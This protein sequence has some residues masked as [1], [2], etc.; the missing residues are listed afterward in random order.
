MKNG[1]LDLS[2]AKIA[3]RNERAKKLY[4]YLSDVARR[5]NDMSTTSKFVAD[6]F[7]TN[8]EVQRQKL[9]DN[10]EKLLFLDPINYGKKALELLWRKVYYD[11]ISTAKKLRTDS[12]H[13]HFLFTLI[14]CGIGNFHHFLDRI[15]YEM[16]VDFKEL[17]YMPNTE[18][19]ELQ[20][21]SGNVELSNFGKSALHSCLIYLGDLSRYAVEISNHFEPTIAARYYL[22]AAHT[23]FTLGM[24]YNQLGNLYLEKNY[25]LD[26]VCFYIHCLNSKNPFEGAMGN[27]TKIF[28]K[29][30]QFYHTINES[31]TLTQVEHIQNTIVNFLSLIE[32]WYLNKSDSDIPQRCS[33]IAQQ[34][35]ICMEFNEATLP[36]I[37]KNY[38]D[39]LSILEHETNF[40]SYLNPNLIHRMVLICLFTVSKMT[41]IDETKAFACKAFTLALL[42]QLLLKLLKQLDSIGFVNPRQI[43]NYGSSKPHNEQ[44]EKYENNN[45][46]NKEI[47]EST[48]NN[49]QNA[50]QELEEQKQNNV[51]ENNLNGHAKHAK[52]ALMKRRRRRRIASSESSDVSDANTES[53]DLDE[54]E[55]SYSDLSDSSDQS[56]SLSEASDCD[57]VNDETKDE[58]SE[59][60]NEKVEPNKILN[61]DITSKITE[62]NSLN[63]SNLLNCNTTKS[64]ENSK[65]NT[66]ELKT[67]LQGNNFMASIKLLLDWILIEKDL[68]LSC[69]DSGESLFQCVVDL[70]NIFTF[71]FNTKSDEGTKEDCELIKYIRNLVMKMKLEYKTIPLPE[72]INLRGTNIC[73]FDK[74]AAEWHILEKYKL[75]VYEE[76]VI[77]ILNFI[78]FGNQ[79][80]KIIPRI[81][82]NRTMKLFYLKNIH[83]PKLNTKINHKRSREWHSKKNTESNESGLL[84]R[85]GRLWLTSQ[86]RELERS[87]QSAAP[88]LLVLDTAALNKH[89]RRVKQ[90]L[91]TTNFVLMVPTVVLQELDNLKREQSTARKAIRWLELQLKNGSR[92]LRAQ[93]PNQSKPLPLLKYP[94]KAPAH[95]NNF[96]QILEFCNHFVAEDKKTQGSG[97][98][99]N[100]LQGKSS[101]VLILLVGNADEDEEQYKEFSVMGAAQSAGIS[102]ENIVDFYSK[103]RQTSHKNGKK[104]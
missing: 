39:Y 18:E 17:D 72:D 31:D 51:K 26:S 56:V 95:I 63:S 41:E 97:D 61:D 103:W 5:I 60:I 64:Q 22:Q 32:I 99:E 88:A 52:K 2:E 101:S 33:K 66:I 23:D 76:N 6:L 10:C 89:L 16:K 85:L 30:D 53:S 87:G 3:E 73:K 28:E 15:H 98:A 19:D 91:L 44:T 94:R 1:C 21:S 13:D 46:E 81:R 77:R 84:R 24:P 104:R 65:V 38:D 47:I 45:D 8:I 82:F 92:F 70:L 25:N 48:V 67:F 86:V 29:N 75:S 102:V 20:L 93:R 36:D 43:H 96:I 11:T 4:R 55:H 57:E 49:G 68:I 79:I 74:D 59:Q 90:L 78:D 80:A 7:T 58:S 71:Y 62:T 83:P 42:S 37:D 40:P 14:Q 54:I 69:G 27:L 100:V 35:K 12:E 9:R 50:E 34:L